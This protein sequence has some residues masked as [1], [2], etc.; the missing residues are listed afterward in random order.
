MDRLE[1]IESTNEMLIAAMRGE[2]ADIWTALPGIVQ[3][4]DPAKMTCSV[5]PTIRFRILPPAMNTYKSATAI[6]DPSGQFM[7]D[8]MPLMTDCPVQFP[9]GGGVTLTFPIAKG[10]EVLLVIASRCID[11]WWAYGG[12]QNQNAAR[13]HDLSD[14]FVIPQVRS[15]ARKFTV[16][17]TAAQIRND[18][19]TA[20]IEMNATTGAVA[21]VCPT[22]TVTA[23]TSA[24]V[25]A[26]TVTINGNLAV[27]GTITATGLLT[28]AS[29]TISGTL[30]NGGK[31][32]GPSHVHTG[33]QTGLGNTGGIL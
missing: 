15:Q 16:S 4:F 25:T 26:P 23:S 3:S 7:W 28:A 22:A 33:V 18:A 20:Y 30:T 2:R 32:I 29:A 13:M 14:G 5:Q 27:N 11:A 6:M 10:D 12:I 1:R 24:T 31:D 8:Q 19:G 9:G 21:V 17:S